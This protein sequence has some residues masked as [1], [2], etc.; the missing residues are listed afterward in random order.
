VVH[1]QDQKSDAL[2]KEDC[3]TAWCRKQHGKGNDSNFGISESMF[4]SGSP[5]AYGQT[6]KDMHNCVI[7]LASMTCCQG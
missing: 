3:S 1:W 6:Q 7:T 2:I 4:L 5:L